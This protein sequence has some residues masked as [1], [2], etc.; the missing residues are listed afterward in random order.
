[1]LPGGRTDV[2]D[3]VGVRDGVFVVLDD[4]QRVAEIPQPREGF[5]E[6][7]VVALMQTDGR[8]VEHV[9][10]TD[11]TRADLGGQPDTLGLTAGERARGTL[12]RQV[13]QSDVEQEAQPRLH[14]LEHLP[15]DGLLARA[16]R[17]RVQEVRAVRDRQRTHLGDGLR[18]TL[19]R[20]QRDRQ[21]LRLEP[22]ALADRA[23]HIAHEAFV[24][25]LHQFGVGLLD[26]AL[27]ERQHALEV[28]VV[29]ADPAVAVLVPDV[30]LL[31]GALENR[32]ARL[33]RQLVPRRVHVE[34]QRV[35]EARHHPGEVLG[36]VA[37]GPRGDGALGQR[38]VRVGHHQVGVDLLADAQPDA[39]RARAVRRVE[40]KR[41]GLKVVDGQRVAVGA[42]QLLGEP[43]LAVR[44][45]VLPVDE[46]QHDDAV[47]EIQRGLDRVGQALLGRSL[48]GEA[49]DHHLDVVLLLLLELGRVGQRMH[50]AVYADPAVTLA[51]ELVEQVD[52]LA[53]AGADHRREHLEPGALVHRQH[54]VDDLLRCLLGDA[55]TAHR[56][57]RRA[58]AGIEQ[59]QIVVDLGD[60]AD[61]RARVAVGGLLI[62][63]HRGRQALDEVDVRLVHLPEELPGIRRQRLDVAALPLGENGVERQRRL[64]RPGQ[65][66]EDDQGVTRQ[67][68]VD[69]AQIVLART[70]DDQ[71]VSHT[72][73]FQLFYLRFCDVTRWTPQT[74][75]SMLFAP[76]DKPTIPPRHEAGEERVKSNRQADDPAEERGG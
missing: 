66:R 62:D 75:A 67:V 33:G 57:V 43:L 10:H 23:R 36:G 26:L 24:A 54:L 14:L 46:L 27:Q 55:L 47:G 28:G 4:D 44:V 52:E 51:V 15:G 35:A 31:V 63:R 38:Q 65:P 37:H 60:G 45:V 64:A 71:A 76:T 13:L 48:D 72:G 21:D 11:Q 39:L 42:G 12:Q 7:P 29:R 20:R 6:S 68:K 9:E 74:S 69:A 22:G 3:P 1:M 53:L 25:L 59:A 41:P 17:E 30:H 58:G 32:L 5:D 19:P 49:V 34:A 8:L 40:R 70:L 56:A 61:R 18:A 16:Q 73:P 50:D 2:D